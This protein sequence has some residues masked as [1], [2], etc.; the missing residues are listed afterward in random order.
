MRRFA[1]LFN[2][3]ESSN[4]TSDKISALTH[5]FADADPASAAWALWI[6]S[7][8]RLPLSIPSR[9]LLEWAA[10][11]AALPNWLVTE[12][13]E[14][15]GDLAETA[16]LLLPPAPASLSGPMSLD[17]WIRQHIQ[18]MQL[19]GDRFQLLLLQDM[20]PMLQP[21]ERF[22]FCKLLTGGFRVGVSRSL[23][24]RA[25]AKTLN[26]DVA[27]LTHRLTGD[28]QPSADFFRSLTDP[29]AN[30]AAADCH[31]Y[32]FFLASPLIH[33]TDILNDLSDWSLEWK[34]DGLRAQLIVRNG[35][36]YL[37]SRGEE[38]LT[39]SFP[40]IVAAAHSLPD[41]TVLDGEIL[42]WRDDS[43]L[44]FHLL[45]SRI[46]RKQNLKDAMR[47]APV[48][49]MGYDCMEIKGEDI[50]Q[51][52]LQQRRVYLQEIIT[53][54]ANATLRLSPQLDISHSDQIQAH[55]RSARS[56]KTEGLMIKRDSSP[57]RSGRV[58][59]DWWKL[60]T[61]P[62][63][64]DLVLTYAQAGHGRRAGL[65]TDYTFAAWQNGTL[66]TVTKAYSGLSDTEMRSLDQWIKKNTLSKKGPVRSVPAHWV[67]EIAFEGIRPSTR[68]KSGVALRFPRILRWRRDK[69]PADADQIE[70]LTHLI[71]NT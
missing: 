29:D 14:Q 50:R 7:G 57:Y 25:L 16:A 3:L 13:Y 26:L 19:W 47:E 39:E 11:L 68:H 38:R 67:F 55:V 1:Q 66:V 45:Q 59:G 44:P 34:W 33:G 21:Q 32:P 63:T 52:P 24:I 18:P 61:D 28:W 6:L 46:N 36:V 10:E 65:F 30:H 8:N 23:V 5:Y 54:A 37:W 2:E 58:R 64:V 60:K 31:P 49:F 4:K 27:V 62:L 22:V 56:R 71:A 40:E 17:T 20:L 41:G 15:T 12:C 51:R 48:I 69:Q 70:A 53:S 42:V 9:R 43:P 35:S